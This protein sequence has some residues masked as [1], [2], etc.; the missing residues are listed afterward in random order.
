MDKLSHIVL[1]AFRDEL[2]NIKLAGKF[3]TDYVPGLKT[4]VERGKAGIKGRETVPSL[5]D[6]VSKA[7]LQ[8]G[9]KQAA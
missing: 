3:K 1:A 9:L 7:K 6:L 4:L 2:E 5:K 8:Q